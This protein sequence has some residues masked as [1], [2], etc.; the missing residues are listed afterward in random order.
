[1]IAKS[2]SSANEPRPREVRLDRLIGREV[3]ARNNRA[4]GRLNE[5][6]AEQ[7]GAGFAITEYVI[8]G[9]GLFERLHLGVKLLFGLRVGGYL[10]RWDQIDLG[11]PD[12]PRLTCPVEELQKL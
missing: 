4:V 12:R 6:R 7:H 2:E 8:G 5:F 3:H 10:A 11:D 1:M 9:A